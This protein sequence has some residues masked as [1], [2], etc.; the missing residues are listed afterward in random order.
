M[1]QYMDATVYIS[2]YLRLTPQ[3]LLGPCIGQWPAHHAVPRY[4]H[5]HLY[6]PK[7]TKVTGFA[8]ST[9]SSY[10]SFTVIVEAEEATPRRQH[11]RREPAE[12]TDL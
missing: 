2:C 7:L 6:L 12:G 5:Q 9:V 4:G 11:G 8:A 10:D 1:C 3:L